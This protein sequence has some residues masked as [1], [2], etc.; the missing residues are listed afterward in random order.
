[1]SWSDSSKL[2]EKGHTDVQPRS[3]YAY[4][5]IDICFCKDDPSFPKLG[6]LKLETVQTVIPEPSAS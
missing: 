2:Q 6:N 1:M 5:I 3:V 4:P